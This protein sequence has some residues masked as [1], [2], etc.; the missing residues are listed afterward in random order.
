VNLAVSLARSGSRVLLVEGNLRR[1]RVARYLGLE[2]RG[3]GL[4]DVLEGRAE[5][6]E[7]LQ[8][9]GDGTLSVLGAGPMPE[10]PDEVLGSP[11]MS[12]LLSVLRDSE[13]FVVIDAPPLLSVVDA[14]VLSTAADG[15][16]IVTRVGRTKRDH[17]GEAVTAVERV[18]GSVLGVVLNRV[19]RAGA[20]APAA[21]R[22]GY[23]ADPDREPARSIGTPAPGGEGNGRI[24]TTP[25]AASSPSQE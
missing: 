19:P 17:L 10:D 22:R 3:P 4:S 15:C 20:V 8:P 25:V 24:T 5:L 7:A 12:A 23:R 9:W 2:E 16:V 21:A 14:A 11:R 18:G 6:R 1:P 13:Q